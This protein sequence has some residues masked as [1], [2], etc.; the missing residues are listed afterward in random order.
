MIAKKALS[1]ANVRLKSVVGVAIFVGTWLVTTGFAN[2][3]NYGPGYPPPLNYGPY[4]PGAKLQI[5]DPTYTSN[6]FWDCSGCVPV[7]GTDTDSDAQWVTVWT[8]GSFYCTTDDGDFNDPDWDIW[9]CVGMNV[10]LNA[11]V[12]Y[13]DKGN[14]DIAEVLEGGGSPF[15][16]SV[17]GSSE[18]GGGVWGGAFNLVIGCFPSDAWNDPE[19]GEDVGGYNGCGMVGPQQNGNGPWVASFDGTYF[20]LN[21]TP[22][23]ITEAT[24]AP[25]QVTKN[26]SV[27]D[28]QTVYIFPDYF[29]NPGDSYEVAMTQE[30]ATIMGAHKQIEASDTAGLGGATASTTCQ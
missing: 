27:S 3:Q 15:V 10:G 24:V 30:Q 14:W 17:T 2:A 9:G 23:N 1:R 22:D 16:F 13:D 12:A 4:G 26:C 28:D 6:T 29:G 11:I 18:C 20:Q 5:V 19:W 7:D 21:P 25:N 8:C